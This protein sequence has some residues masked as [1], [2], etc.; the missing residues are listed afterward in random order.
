MKKIGIKQAIWAQLAI[1]LIS[2]IIV[3]VGSYISIE[4]IGATANAQVKS[5][6][7]ASVLKDLKFVNSAIALECRKIAEAVDEGDTDSVEDH[8]TLLTEYFSELKDIKERV[9]V[10]KILAEDKNIKDKINF[11]IDSLGKLEPVVRDRFIPAAKLGEDV[12]MYNS[13][14]V[15]RTDSNIDNLEIVVTAAMKNVNESM[16]ALEK[17]QQ[18]IETNK[19]TSSIVYVFIITILVVLSLFVVKNIYYISHQ[20]SEGLKSFFDFLNREQ[21]LIKHIEM[22]YKDEFGSM[23]NMINTNV[24]S[25]KEGLDRDQDYIKNVIDTFELVAKGNLSVRVSSNTFN[26]ELLILSGVINQMLDQMQ[27]TMGKDLNLIM[28]ILNS[29]ATFDFSKK[30]DRPEGKL[31]LIVNSLGE[32][33]VKILSENENNTQRLQE[34]T[35]SLN[36]ILLELRKNTVAQLHT[37]LNSVVAQASIISENENLLATKLNSLNTDAQNITDITNIIGDIADQTNLLALNAAIEAARA[38]VHGR[39]FAVVADEVRSLAEKTQD[40]TLKISHSIELIKN[41]ILSNTTNINQNVKSM[42]QLVA[43]IAKIEK[44]MDEVLQIFDSIDNLK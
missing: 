44:T 27:M 33:S 23:A 37:L 9:E 40:S 16:S 7:E 6:M 30:I 11:I 10:K 4:D 31:E 41:D 2:F 36:N 39:G 35:K 5:S 42:N 38:G 17:S 32:Y 18:N 43:S 26:P 29:F 25:I 8:E 13:I 28:S 20:M 1:T 24:V 3:G 15:M 12:S 14:V 22:P 19:I 21:S 34:Y